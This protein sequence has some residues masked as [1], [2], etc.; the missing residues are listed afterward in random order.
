MMVLLSQKEYNSLVSKAIG[1]EAQ[2]EIRV[3]E[4]KRKI[5]ERLKSRMI[6]SNNLKYHSPI[7]AVRDAVNDLLR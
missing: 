1:L 3:E 6:E 7:E 4:E 2:V 5:L